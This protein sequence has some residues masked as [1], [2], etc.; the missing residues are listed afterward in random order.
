MLFN[1]HLCNHI[2]LQIGGGTWGTVLYTVRGVS[3][4]SRDVYA[5]REQ[6]GLYAEDRGLQVPMTLEHFQ[7]GMFRP[8]RV[9][10]TN[11]LQIAIKIH[12]FYVDS[13]VLDTGRRE[14]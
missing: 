13:R 4:G 3:S 8:I 5:W 12:S 2:L 1:T 7:I 14:V 10:H 6:T 11:C 9:D